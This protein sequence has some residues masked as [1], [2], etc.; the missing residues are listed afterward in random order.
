MLIWN[1]Y[2][3]IF[4]F[5]PIISQVS[6]QTWIITFVDFYFAYVSQSLRGVIEHLRFKGLLNILLD[7]FWNIIHGTSFAINANFRR[8]VR[9]KVFFLNMKFCVVNRNHLFLKFSKNPFASS[10]CQDFFYHKNKQLKK[11]M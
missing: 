1:I 8:T 11:F 5:L 4:L 7:I 6:N 9:F 2:L 3:S 10:F